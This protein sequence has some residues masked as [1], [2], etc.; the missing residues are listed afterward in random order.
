MKNNLI[1][2]AGGLGTRLKSVVSEVPKP[3]A[4]I[5]NKPFLE[6]LINYFDKQHIDNIFL[7]VGYKKELIDSFIKKSFYKSN[8]E[9]IRENRPLG[10]GGA[11]NNVLNNIKDEK[12]FFVVNGDTFLEISLEDLRNFH[13]NCKNDISIALVKMENFDR[14]GSVEV[15]DNRIIS[16]NEKK[17]CESAYINAGVYLLNR[18]IFK[19][20]D[21]KDKFSFEEFLSNNLND[22]KVGG[23]LLEKSYFIDIG[24]PDDYKKAQSDFK[25]LF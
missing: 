11:I 20:Y 19:K 22:L 13:Y 2:L 25:E 18:D 9:L 5:N 23:I 15:K 24:I 1:I 12:D 4:P 3:L 10:T 21:L 17:F 14:Y 16:F 8:I 7:S 6:Y